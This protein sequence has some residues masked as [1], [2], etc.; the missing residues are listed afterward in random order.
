MFHYFLMS[1][2]RSTSQTQKQKVCTMRAK[3]NKYENKTS[4]QKNLNNSDAYEY[5]I[6]IRNDMSEESKV[7]VTENKGSIDKLL[8]LEKET[9]CSEMQI[10]QTTTVGNVIITTRSSNIPKVIKKIFF[11]LYQFRQYYQQIYPEKTTAF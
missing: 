11:L 1:F 10:G 9:I 3:G 6:A 7:Q 4:P 8:Q 5:C 2:H